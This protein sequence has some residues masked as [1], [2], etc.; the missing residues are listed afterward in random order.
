MEFS[1]ASLDRMHPVNG[2]G[3]NRV[4]S[5]RAAFDLESPL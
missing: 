2:L 1:D 5:P 3:I 4:M